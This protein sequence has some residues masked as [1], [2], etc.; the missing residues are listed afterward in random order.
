VLQPVPHVHLAVH[1]CRGSELFTGLLAFA[2]ASIE[3]AEAKV[4]EGDKWPHPA[5]VGQR[6]STAVTI[7]G[8]L[9]L[10]PIRMREDFTREVQ[11]KHL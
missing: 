5:F 2:S 9:E 10:P 8:R 6:L 4:A 11:D 7:L 3:F 1:R